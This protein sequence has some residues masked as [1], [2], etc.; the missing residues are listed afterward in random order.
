MTSDNTEEGK[1]DVLS[2]TRD[3]PSLVIQ[4]SQVSFFSF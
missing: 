4:G 2:N 1:I 3:S